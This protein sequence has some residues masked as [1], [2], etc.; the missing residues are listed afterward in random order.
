MAPTCK[1]ELQ[2]LESSLENVGALNL[3]PLAKSKPSRPQLVLR[4]LMK[5]RIWFRTQNNTK[6][7]EENFES[8]TRKAW[9]LRKNAP[10]SMRF[11][12][13]FLV[14]ISEV[15]RGACA[16][17]SLTIV[18][19]CSAPEGKEAGRVK[20]KNLCKLKHHACS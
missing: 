13:R 18:I 5:L 14:P 17:S 4:L 6:R 2:L 16:R 15:F 8:N 7:K 20:G 10:L 9:Q 3:R 12:R 11:K 1:F 19:T